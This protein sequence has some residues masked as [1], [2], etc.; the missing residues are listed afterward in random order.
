M[1]SNKWILVASGFVAG[2][3]VGVVIMLVASPSGGP[4]AGSS[5]PAP[6]TP[7]QAPQAGPDKLKLSREIAQLEDIL[8][9]D[10][11]NYDGLVSLGN[12]Y[13]DLGEAQKSIDAYRKALAIRGNDPNVWTDMG[14]MYRQTRDFK[15]AA[16]AFRKAIALDPRHTTSRFNLGV[17]MVHDLNDPKAGIE[18][19]EGFL[20][21]EPTG[22]RAEQ[23]RAQLDEL[24]KMSAK[25][26]DLDKAA[27]TLGKQLNQPAAK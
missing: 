15:S 7:G 4:G 16:D 21:V 3:I 27:Q 20:S 11:A 12:D 19:W 25:Q 14:V 17:V 22:P 2:L 6:V 18:A 10:P 5:A 26:S 13:F 9:K 8:R 23:V 1:S 24:R